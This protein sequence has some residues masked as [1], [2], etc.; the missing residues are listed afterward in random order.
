[1]ALY[2]VRGEMVA[3]NYFETLG[4]PL[5]RGRTFTEG[6][7]SGAAGLCA[8]IAYQ[9]WTNQFHGAE[10]IVG[11]TLIVN[12]R[13]ATI[14]GIAAEG[15]HGVGLVP[16]FEI[17]LP[18]PGFLRDQGKGSRLADRTWG[19]V[20]VIGRLAPGVSLSQAKEEFALLAQRLQV[21][22]PGEIPGWAPV[23]A[24]YPRTVFG[25]IRLPKPGA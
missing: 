22:H 9:I 12:G 19:G 16:H 11:Q 25:P 24:R 6:E 21:L 15:F 1:M 4:V 7:A 5:V 17:G 8:V 18:L 2:E 23:L 13:R 3:A 14:V 20:T 10:N